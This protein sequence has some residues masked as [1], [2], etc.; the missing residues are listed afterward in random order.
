[1]K[2]DRITVKNFKSVPPAGVEINFTSGLVVL[3]G[4]NNAG[5]SN[6]LEATGLLFGSKNPRY[7]AVPP[8]RFNDPAQDIVIEAEFSGVTWGDGKHLGFSDSQCGSL[9]HEGKRVQTAAGHITF[10]LTIPPVASGE[11]DPGD[12]EGDEGAERKRSFEVF[13]ANRYE[14]KRNEE[15]RKALIKYLVVPSVRDHS[16]L[17]APSTWT[18]Y[19]NMLRAI[20]SESDK[21]GDLQTL[22]DDASRQL[23]AILKQEATTLT[24]CAKTT[25]YV[26]NIDFQLTKDGNLLELLRNL[27]VSVSYG[28]R[29][30]DISLCGTGTQSAVIIGVLEL[31]LR[32]RSR[33]GIRLFVVEEPELF[34]HPHAQRHVA[35]LLRRIARE[36]SSQVIL[37]THAASVLAQTDM[38]DVVRVDRSGDGA[39][40]CLRIEAAPERIDAWERTLT[41]ETC[42]M[43]FADRVGLVEGPSESILLP[44]IAK[45]ITAGDK[46]LCD[47]D[48]RNVSVVNVGGKERFKVFTELLD[49]VQVEWRIITDRDAIS[50]DT[51]ATFKAR[52]GVEPTAPV[53]DQAVALRKVGVAVL[54]KGEIE[55]YYPLAALA[56]LAGCSESEAEQ[57]IADRRLEFEDPTARTLVES[58]IRDHQKEICEADSA[59]LHKLVTKWYDQSLQ[60]MRAGG[61]VGQ[62]ERKTGD[63]LSRWLKMSKPELAQRV[64]TWMVEDP[65]RIPGPL[66]RLVSWIVEPKE[67]LA[68]DLQR[69]GSGPS[70]SE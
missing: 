33:T 61:A 27:S 69:E 9:T 51:L 11:A 8:D 56:E 3:V 46:A 21:L 58:V 17:L 59:R 23:Q 65:D 39:T 24:K 49:Q 60:A 29:T 45:R 2:L 5:K 47:L 32:H 1:M 67:E 10:R 37:T 20:L 12:D 64:A 66:C 40:R 50:G 52:S 36:Q 34:L 53:K 44:R 63:V 30:E 4:K 6:I 16:E 28:S 43:F 31:C 19:G 38:L 54:S 18:A 48:R 57:A 70:P 26:D 7:I 25:A 15:F 35:D 13:L 55:D 62:L 14:L 68:A 42:E 22:I 41:A